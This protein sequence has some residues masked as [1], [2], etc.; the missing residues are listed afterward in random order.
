MAQEFLRKK[1]YTIIEKNYQSSL[2][3]IDI[4]AREG[5][6]LIFVEVKIRRS[7][8]FGPAKAAVGLRKQ[9]KLSQVALTYLNHHRL[10]DVPARFDVVAIDFIGG[11]PAVEL[12]RNAFDLQY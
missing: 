3:E 5:N 7:P 11:Q 1:G 10:K 9:R 12:I 6:V 4:V 8:D 2:G